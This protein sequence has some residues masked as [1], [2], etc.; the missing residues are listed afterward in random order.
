P[1]TGPTPLPAAASTRS[2]A[3]PRGGPAAST[4]PSSRCAQ[5]LRVAATSVSAGTDTGPA[6]RRVATVVGRSGAGLGALHPAAH[7][8]RPGRAS[9]GRSTALT[10]TTPQTPALPLTGA[11][12]ARD[13]AGLPVPGATWPRAG[14]SE[15][16]ASEL[17]SRFD[18]V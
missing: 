17:Q 8:R 3:R 1:G 9:R 4:T 16:P 10:S 15:A 11:L 6:P 14:R 12:N 2:A 5:R 18:L 13:L 7:R